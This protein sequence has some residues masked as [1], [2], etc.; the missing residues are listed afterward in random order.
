MPRIAKHA[1][2]A[3]RERAFDPGDSSPW[4]ERPPRPHRW[5]RKPRAV[6]VG[7]LGAPAMAA[8]AGSSEPE[9]A[10]RVATPAGLAMHVCVARRTGRTR[11]GCEGAS[12]PEH[13]WA[14]GAVRGPGVKPRNEHLR[15]GSIRRRSSD[16][17]R[18]EPAWR[19]ATPEQAAHDAREVD[20]R[21]GCRS[22]LR[23]HERIPP[24]AAR[25]LVPS[26]GKRSGDGPSR[27]DIPSS[28]QERSRWQHRGRD[29]S[30]AQHLG[31]IRGRAGCSGARSN[32]RVQ[33]SGGARG[34]F[35]SGALDRATARSSGRTAG[36]PRLDESRQAAR[37]SPAGGDTG[38]GLS[39]RSRFRR[40]LRFTTWRRARAGVL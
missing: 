27:T 19:V 25:R 36:G 30:L 3:R 37:G 10:P 11:N 22:L 32:R 33:D 29:G 23:C 18:F 13:G 24:R 35:G 15:R 7:P 40:A 2:P 31:A 5:G 20:D 38:G 39:D 4:P 14:P 21:E 34:S 1:S 17:G 28:G 12:A 6:V 9:A 8:H 16:A 26:F